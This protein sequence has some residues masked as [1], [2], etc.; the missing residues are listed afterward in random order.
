MTSWAGPLPSI[1]AAMA[2]EAWSANVATQRLV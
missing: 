2:S 1:L